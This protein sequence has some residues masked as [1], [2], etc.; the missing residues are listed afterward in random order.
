MIT[1]V[2]TVFQKLTKENKISC[3]FPNSLQLWQKSFE[4]WF[5]QVEWIEIRLCNKFTEHFKLNS[6]YISKNTRIWI[7]T[8]FIHKYIYFLPRSFPCPEYLS[9]HFIEEM[10]LIP[11][12]ILILSY[13]FIGPWVLL[14]HTLLQ[15]PAYHIEYAITEAGLY[16]VQLIPEADK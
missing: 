16:L 6:G 11:R 7:G 1:S 8:S 15:L 4:L 9:N 3:I 12:V 14:F 13:S 5:C 10:V 2:I